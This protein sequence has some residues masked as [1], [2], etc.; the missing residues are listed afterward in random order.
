M[1]CRDK[2]CA[3]LCIQEHLCAPSCLTEL[4]PSGSQA[5]GS[6]SCE[7]RFLRKIS[8]DPEYGCWLKAKT[9]RV[10]QGLF[11]CRY[12][13][14][15]CVEDVLMRIRSGA[16]QRGKKHGEKPPS[17]LSH[18]LFQDAQ[19]FS[20]ILWL[21]LCERTYSFMALCSAFAFLWGIALN[22]INKIC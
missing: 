7:G 3:L 19:V 18:C 15:A 22:S 16:E 5:G 6:C 9:F 21:Q 10:Q 11:K 13:K 8:W 20:G 17:S 4:C 12:L 1:H 2:S 14:S